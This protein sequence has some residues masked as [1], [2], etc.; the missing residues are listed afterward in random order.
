MMTILSTED[1][2]KEG[3]FFPVTSGTSILMTEKDKRKQKIK[4]LKKKVYNYIAQKNRPVLMSELINY[5]GASPTE[6][7][8]V[9]RELEKEGLI[10]EAD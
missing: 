1:L 4:E 5:F 10:R 9:L 8:L 2:I 3:L 7:H 6:I